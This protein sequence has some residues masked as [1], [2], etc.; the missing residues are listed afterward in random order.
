M[1]SSAIMD[2]EGGPAEATGMV[3]DGIALAIS[4][5][6]GPRVGT[7][8]LRGEGISPLS[9]EDISPLREEGISLLRGE[10]ISPPREADI[11]PLHEEGILSHREEGIEVVAPRPGVPA[12]AGIAEFLALH[13][14]CGKPSPA[15]LFTEPLR[16]F[17]WRFMVLYLNG[18]CPGNRH[19]TGVIMDA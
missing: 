19:G 13:N 12:Q 5:L 10:G 9:A 11:S 15:F 7:S 18:I 17:R 1:D 2:T 16:K 8:P 4:S 6:P 14:I 3:K